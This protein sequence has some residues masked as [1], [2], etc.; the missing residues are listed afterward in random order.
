MT[1]ELLLDVARTSLSTKVPPALAEHLTPIVVSDCNTD[2]RPE[3]TQ[4]SPKS[5]LLG[6][7]R[8]GLRLRLFSADLG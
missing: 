2:T 5:A 4:P 7:P 3:K 8:P 6:R 1:R